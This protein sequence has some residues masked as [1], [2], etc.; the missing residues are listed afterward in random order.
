MHA[1][2]GEGLE[3]LALLAQIGCTHSITHPSIDTHEQAH[4]PAPFSATYRTAL[5]QDWWPGMLTLLVLS[6]GEGKRG[7]EWV[8]FSIVIMK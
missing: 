2:H 6:W 1:Y 8:I 3:L 7:G 4:K 5:A